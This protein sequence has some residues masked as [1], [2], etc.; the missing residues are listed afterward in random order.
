[1]RGLLLQL[2]VKGLSEEFGTEREQGGFYFE[3]WIGRFFQDLLGLEIHQWIIRAGSLLIVC[4]LVFGF[5]NLFALWAVWAERKISAHIQCRLGPMEVGP[6]GLL[7]TI[8]DGMKLTFKEDI[9]PRLADR[10]LFILAPIVVFTGILVRF[11]PLPFGEH[12]V[13]SDMDLGLFFLAA[14]GSIEVLGVI[15]AGWASN[16]KWAM[17]GTIRTA[18]QM[19]SYEIPIGIAFVTVI[20]SFGTFSLV[21][22]VELQ[23]GL[24]MD[25]D[26]LVQSGWFWHWTIFRNP[27]LLLLG[28]VYLVSSLAECKR[29]PFDLPEAESELVS[30]FHTE[31]SGMRFALFFLAEYGAMYLVSAV[32]A[33]IFFGGWWTGI[34]WIDA[35]G[36]GPDAS[37]LVQASGFFIKAATL[38]SKA[39][40]L[41]CIQMWVRWTLPR[42]RLD[43]MMHV[44][45]KV[46][47]PASVVCLVGSCLWEIASGGGTFMG[48][49][50]ETNLVSGAP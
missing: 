40:F 5:L 50:M 6:H 15:M 10:P 47:L 9:I 25:G 37:P 27:F 32:A 13:A 2:S 20:V 26:R 4:G 21:D 44:C 45:W 38:I 12:L 23:G 7:Q 17:F 1:M 36:L 30:G 46:L 35:I 14:V 33:C 19:V 18:A 29:A 8:A 22:I 11:V 42:V 31:Y 39:L 24:I 48:F 28:L 41:V 16:N 49:G 43:Q 3:D 34:Y